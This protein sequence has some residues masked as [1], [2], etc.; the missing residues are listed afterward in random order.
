M[1]ETA[2]AVQPM[3]WCLVAFVPLFN[4]M[5]DGVIIVNCARG[6]II[7]EEALLK[8]LN[9]GKVRCRLEQQPHLCADERTIVKCRM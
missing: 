2:V 6:G 5:K 4:Q 3:M 9:S 1:K 8:A 7:N